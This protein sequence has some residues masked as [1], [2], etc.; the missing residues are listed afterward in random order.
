MDGETL[1]DQSADHVKPYH[2]YDCPLRI[3]QIA[4]KYPIQ[5]FFLKVPEGSC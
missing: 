4:N 1:S 2:L 3:I 5:F